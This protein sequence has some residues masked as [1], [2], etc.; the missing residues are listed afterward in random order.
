MYKNNSLSNRHSPSLQH[1]NR[2]V[3]ALY[4][5]PFVQVTGVFELVSNHRFDMKLFVEAQTYE[6][7]TL[8]TEMKI[9]GG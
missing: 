7:A 6:G 1:W 5:C 4:G 3:R 2:E 9:K 8:L